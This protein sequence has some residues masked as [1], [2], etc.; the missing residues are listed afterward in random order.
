[1]KITTASKALKHFKSKTAL[2]EHLGIQRNTLDKYLCDTKGEY[3]IV[4]QYGPKGDYGF[5][6]GLGKKAP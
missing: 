2:A 3:H 5:F 4:V 6:A 1:M